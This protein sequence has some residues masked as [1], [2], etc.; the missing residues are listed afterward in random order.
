MQSLIR[1]TT[2]LTYNLLKKYLNPE[3]L[4]IGLLLVVLSLNNDIKV[5][6]YN[7]LS[8]LFYIVAVY[9]LFQGLQK[10]KIMNILTGGFFVGLNVFIRAPNILEGGIVTGNFLLSVFEP[11]QKTIKLLKQMTSLSAGFL[12]AFVLY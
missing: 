7:T 5:L 8:S 12:A 9:F 2:I 11:I 1:C 4:K 6:N 3:Y 10:N